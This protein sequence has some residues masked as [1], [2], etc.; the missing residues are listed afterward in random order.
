MTSNIASLS[1]SS[2][3][4]KSNNFFS[5]DKNLFSSG[6]GSD[7]V[8]TKENG[9]PGPKTNAAPKQ[10][11]TGAGVG[12][13]GGGLFDDDEDEDFFSGKS[14]KTSDSGEFVRLGTSVLPF[15]FMFGWDPH[16]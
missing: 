12:G 7:S 16:P 8:E 2:S 15:M 11:S 10:V 3:S 5:T 9:T 13:G 14:L 1:T 6:N 4:N